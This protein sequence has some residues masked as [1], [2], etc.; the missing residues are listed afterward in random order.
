VP[1]RWLTLG[2]SAATECGSRPYGWLARGWSSPRQ[3]LAAVRTARPGCAPRWP[4]RPPT[5]R[6]QVLTEVA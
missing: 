5:V 3:R 2:Q 6:V 4:V 1:G